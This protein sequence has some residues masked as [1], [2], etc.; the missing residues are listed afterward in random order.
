[1]PVSDVVFA[2]CCWGALPV[3]APASRYE[4]GTPIPASNPEQSIALMCLE[5]G[6]LAFVG[7][8][9]SHYSPVEAPYDNAAGPMHRFFW[10]ETAA[11]HAP[12]AALFN[13]KRRY[14]EE[15]PT[16]TDVVDLATRYKTL[17]Q[18]TCLGLGW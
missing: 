8:T 7:C 18:F 5:R 10:E 14:A 16:V 9:G 11:G 13:A 3:S 4:T 1:M 6:A 2:G 12:A 15:L 17:V